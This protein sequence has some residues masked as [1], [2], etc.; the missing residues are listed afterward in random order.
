MDTILVFSLIITSYDVGKK[1]LRDSSCH[2]EQLPGLFPKD[3]R[4]IRDVLMQEAQAEA[5]KSTFIQNQTVAT[6]QCFGPGSKV[7]VN[8]VYSERRS[9]VKQTLKNLRV[10]AAPHRNSTASPNC[11]LTPTSKFQTGALLTGKESMPGSQRAMPMPAVVEKAKE[12]R[13]ATCGS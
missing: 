10:I 4:K 3:V 9:K 5:Q 12:G 7:K 8:L 2:V 13:P 1:E 11:H 6:L